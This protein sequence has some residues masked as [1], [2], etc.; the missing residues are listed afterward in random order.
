MDFVVLEMK[1]YCFTPI[2]LGRPLLATTR[3]MIDVDKTKIAI[4]SGREYEIFR[5]PSMSPG[6]MKCKGKN[7][8]T[9][10][11]ASLHAK[12]R[13]KKRSLNDRG[14]RALVRH[15]GQAQDVKHALNRRQPIS[16]S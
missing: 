3:E 5:F 10:E 7:S 13:R 1:E 9:K 6:K 4:R 2:L 12:D 8:R 16:S 14:S 15:I 11:K